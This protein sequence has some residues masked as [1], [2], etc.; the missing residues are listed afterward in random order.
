M[1]KQQV[2]D[3]KIKRTLMSVNISPDYCYRTVKNYDGSYFKSISLELE[4]KNVVAKFGYKITDTPIS[5]SLWNVGLN[6]LC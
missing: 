5:T 2:P 4:N 1:L 6:I 3:K